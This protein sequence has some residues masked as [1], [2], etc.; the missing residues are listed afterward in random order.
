MTHHATP[1]KLQKDMEFFH[2]TMWNFHSLG[3]LHPI[4][5]HISI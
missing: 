5:K 4:H 1:W 3:T 2:I